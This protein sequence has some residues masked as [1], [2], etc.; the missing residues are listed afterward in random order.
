MFKDSL[1]MIIVLKMFINWKH[2]FTFTDDQKQHPASNSMHACEA[3]RLSQV[4]EFYSFFNKWSATCITN[5][6]VGQMAI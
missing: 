2:A 1:C 5:V 6:R 4:A 3:E